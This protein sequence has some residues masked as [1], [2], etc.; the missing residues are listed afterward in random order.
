MANNQNLKNI[1]NPVDEAITR[2][3]E[4]PYYVN[5]NNSEL[6]KA[7]DKLE[8]LERIKS[9]IMGKIFE[10]EIQEKLLNQDPDSPRSQIEQA[11][12]RLNKSAGKIED[13]D[14]FLSDI[15]KALNIVSSIIKAISPIPIAPKKQG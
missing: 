11:T 7:N 9:K 13:F 8:E 6:Q 15:D 1:L 10:Q 12:D 14:N 5:L 2:A 4:S 3:K